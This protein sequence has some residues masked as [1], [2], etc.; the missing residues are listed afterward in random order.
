[1]PHKELSVWNIR[2]TI[3]KGEYHYA[4]VPEH[5]N[6][7]KNGYVL[8]H[9]VVIENHLERL[10]NNDEVVHHIDGNKFN[11]TLNNLDVMSRAEHARLHASL[12]L[13]KIVE[14]KCPECGVRFNRAY[15][16]THLVGSSKAEHGTFCSRSC[17]GKFSRKSQLHGLTAEMKDA[18]SV[19]IQRIYSGK[20]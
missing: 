17:N 12:N 5:P 1:M 13:K 10:L 15:N 20:L 18:I 6:A 3:K 9:R 7:T 2:K 8:M 16:Q 11:N 19:N 4:L 14:L